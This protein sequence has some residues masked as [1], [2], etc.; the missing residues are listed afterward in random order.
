M[1]MNTIFGEPIKDWLNEKWNQ[2]KVSID[3]Y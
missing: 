2:M 3:A 1:K